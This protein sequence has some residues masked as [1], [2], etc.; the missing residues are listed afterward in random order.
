MF[1]LITL[2]KIMCIS[3]LSALRRLISGVD[4][5]PSIIRQEFFFSFHYKPDNLC[6]SHYNQPFKTIPFSCVHLI[7]PFHFQIFFFILLHPSI[8]QGTHIRYVVCSSTCSFVNFWVVVPPM[9]LQHFYDIRLMEG[10]LCPPAGL[11]W[12]L[13]SEGRTLDSPGFGGDSGTTRPHTQG[14]AKFTP[15]LV[16]RE[17]KKGRSLCLPSVDLLYCLTDG[18]TSGPQHLLG[19]LLSVGS[20]NPAREAETTPPP[21]PPAPGFS[22]LP[23]ALLT[24]RYPH[25]VNILEGDE[26]TQHSCDE[27]P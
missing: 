2:F 9:V 10:Q 4:I 18:S 24:A 25:G 13:C 27:I 16:E 7:I 6:T 19:V 26:I 21:R 23:A 20:P 11:P 3:L 12:L 1:H 5:T 14:P 22:I 17:S 15:S 8:I